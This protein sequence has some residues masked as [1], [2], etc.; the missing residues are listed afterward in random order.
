M[1]SNSSKTAKAVVV[2]IFI[3]YGLISLISYVPL[4]HDWR[5]AF[6]SSAAHGLLNFPSRFAHAAVLVEAIGMCLSG[7]LIHRSVKVP[8]SLVAL[9]LLLSFIA[10]ATYVVTL[11]LAIAKLGNQAVRLLDFLIVARFFQYPLLIYGLTVYLQKEPATRG[12]SAPI[13]AYCGYSLKGLEEPRCPECGK[14]YSLD[15]YYKL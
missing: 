6:Q 4:V 8:R 1:S 3:G 7:W 13:C 2:P 11:P 14:R 15:E 12:E 9:V 10:A 5:S